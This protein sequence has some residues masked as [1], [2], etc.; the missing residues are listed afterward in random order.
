MHREAPD[1]RL[2]ATAA[3]AEI[4]K[5]RRY[6]DPDLLYRKD[7]PEPPE[8]PD[9]ELPSVGSHDVKPENA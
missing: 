4:R 5:L 1:T 2:S 8:N 6:M 9:F 3:L 7:I